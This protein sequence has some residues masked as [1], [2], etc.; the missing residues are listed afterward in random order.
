[1]GT[2]PRLIAGTDINGPRRMAYEL[3]GDIGTIPIDEF[4]E[5][6]EKYISKLW[7]FTE[8]D[9]FRSMLM[10]AGRAFGSPYNWGALWNERYGTTSY[11][12]G[13]VDEDG[14]V[15]SDDAVYLLYY[16]LLPESYPVS[17][18]VDYDGDGEITSDDAVY[19]LYYTLLPDSY[20]LY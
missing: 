12:I 4:C 11:I 2:G 15:T 1:M 6:Y 3:W 5:K 7:T 10:K 19:L 16:T 9:T 14:E 8:R 20:P 17:Q 18:P 13:D